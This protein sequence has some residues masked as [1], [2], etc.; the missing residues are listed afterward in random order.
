VTCTEYR[1]P[2]RRKRTVSGHVWASITV[3]M[4]KMLNFVRDTNL[5]YRTLPGSAPSCMRCMYHDMYMDLHA[6]PRPLIY[7][8]S[9]KK[10]NKEKKNKNITVQNACADWCLW[11]PWATKERE[12]PLPL[13]P[14]AETPPIVASNAIQSVIDINTTAF[15]LPRVDDV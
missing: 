2:V 6:P 5:F 1:F 8:C 14:R 13:C 3:V 15:Q 12:S 4:P 10:E 9:R 7:L 11:G